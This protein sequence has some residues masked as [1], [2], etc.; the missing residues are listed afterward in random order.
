[1]KRIP[2]HLFSVLLLIAGIFPVH[3]QQAVGP[4]E[5]RTLNVTYNL[6]S[7]RGV[8]ISN[9]KG[10][11][12]G[13][14]GRAPAQGAQLSPLPTT[15][16]TARQFQSVVTFGGGVR[17]KA[18]GVNIN[19]GG[20]VANAVGLDLPRLGNT[21]PLYVLLRSQVGAPVVSRNLSVLFGG[22]ISVPSTDEFGKLL[23]P[24]VAK[25]S[26]WT[27]EP[28]STDGHL[29]DQ[30]Y[31]SPNAR[32]VFAT[33]PGAI[34]ITWRRRIGQTSA[35]VTQ[36]N[37]VSLLQEGGLWYSLY[38][39][40]LVVSGTL[41]KP[42]KP[43][44]W[45]ARDFA[46][47]GKPVQ[48][49]AGRVSD[50]K[51]V[52]NSQ[53]PARVDQ[54]YSSGS[55]I[56][57]NQLPETR[58]VWF[59]KQ[60]SQ[61]QAYNREGRVFIELLGDLKADGSRQ[62]LGFELVDV[63]QQANPQDIGVELG[64]KLR[65]FSDATRDDSELF[66]QSVLTVGV[67]YFDTLTRGSSKPPILYATRETQN[68]NDVLVYWM[69]TG[70][71]GLLW[72]RVL[73]RYSMKWPSDSARYSHYLRP[74]VSS[75]VEAQ[76]TAVALPRQNIPALVYQDPLDQERAKVTADADFYSYLTP[77]YPAH[78]TLLRYT[79]SDDYVYERVLSWL[80]V[81][82]KSNLWTG[83]VVTN[84]TAYNPTNLSIVFSEATLGPRIVNSTAFVGSRVMAPQGELGS[85]PGGLYVAGHIRKSVGTSYNPAAY[86]DPLVD[87]FDAAAKGS[88][89]PV[90]AIPGSNQLEVWWFR[91]SSAIVARGLSPIA[92]P[93][94]IGR[95][96]LQYPAAAAELVLASN[97]GTKALDSLQ[98][99][100][101]IYF[102]NDRNAPGYNP[103]E[104]HA[105]MV[106]GQGWALRDDLNITNGANF[107]S[108]P[109]VLIA[110]DDADGRPSMAAFKVLREKP[111]DGYLFDYVVDAGTVVQ[112]PMP[113]PLLPLPLEGTTNYNNEV[114]VLNGNLPVNWN[115]SRDANG[116][117]SHYAQFTIRDRKNAFWVYRGL[118]Q[119][120]A[121]QSGSYNPTTRA[122]TVL[123]KAVAVVGQD[124][125]YYIHASRR[126]A[127]LVLKSS[128]ATPL[129]NWLR[130]D[131]DFE[132]VFLAGSP[133]QTNGSTTYSLI[134]TDVGAAQTNNLDFSL[135]VRSSGVVGVQGPL[136]LSMTTTDGSNVEFRGRPPYLAQRASDTNSFR[137]RYY[138]KTLD[139]FAWPS[140]STPVPVG[141]IVPYLR[142]V[143]GA[144]TYVGTGADKASTALDIVYRPAWPSL[145]PVLQ[146]GQT[147]T[148]ATRGL[149][150]IRGQ[151]SLKVLYQQSIATNI[152]TASPSVVLHDP[153]RAKYASLSDF[154]LDT[155]PSS[156]VATG[157][158]GKFYF[159]MLPPH[160]VGR[161]YF[162]PALGTKGS[163][164]LKG[165]FKDEQV[166][167]KY[168]RL[169]VLRG[170]GSKDDFASVLGLCSSS[171]ADDFPKWTNLV[172]GLS[173]SVETFKESSIKPGT[174]IVDPN[175]T[176]QVGVGGLAEIVN[177][178]T[179]V[180]SYAL[181]TPGPGYGY[182]TLIAGNGA[183]FTS[184][185]DP[186]SMYILRV[187]GGLWPGELKVV[188]SPNP[189]NEQLTL[190]HTADVGGRY[191]QFEY[192]WRISA[193]VDG[194]A[195][196]TKDM[197]QWQD[198][199]SGTGLPR[200]TLGGSG[201]QVLSDNY[202]IMRYRSV[203]TNDPVVG[204]WSAWTEPQL[205]EGW[206]KRVLAGIN[207]FAQRVTD[208]YNNEVNTDV[209]VI[210]QAGTRW[211]GAVP[212]NLNSAN[213]SGLISIYETVARRA[214]DLSIN[215]GI[216]YGPGNDALLL[217][218]G[219]LNDLYDIVGNEANADASNPTIATTAVNGQQDA[220]STARFSFSGQVSSLLEEELALLRGR[221][222]FAAP[223]VQSA[224]VYNRLYWNYTRGIDS[225]EVVYAL[226]YNMK[227]LNNDGAVN[228]SDA[229][230]A[231]PQGHGDAYGH[232][233]TA[234]KGYYGLLMNQSF[235]WVPRT[236]AVTIL[237]K[238]VAVDYQDER[239]FAATAS[240]LAQ[241]GLDV[242]KLVF[243]QG[244]KS[245][246]GLGWSNL[247][248]T[249]VNTNR[250]LPSTRYWGLDHWASRVGQGAYLH[251]LVSNSLLPDVD[252]DPSHEGIQKIDRTTVAELALLPSA[253]DEA[254]ALVDSAE[255]GLTPLGLSR[256]SVAF[257]L[258]P[259]A[260]VG[261]QSKTH[262]EQV[263]DRAVGA[264]KNAAAAYG[265]ASTISLN[266]QTESNSLETDKSKIV[267]TERSMTEK[268]I[269]LYG[270][271]YPDDIGVGKTYPQD[272]NGPDLMHYLYV[273]MP[274]YTFPMSDVS[275]SGT[276]SYTF[277]VYDIPADMNFGSYQTV[278]TGFNSEMSSSDLNG[279]YVDGLLNGFSTVTNL[280]I[281]IT[282]E[283]YT[284]R[285]PDWSTERA[286][287]GKIQQAVS[288]M[289]DSQ[290]ML[291]K[292]WDSFA[293]SI[294]VWQQS[295]AVFRAN[296]ETE[297]EIRNSQIAMEAVKSALAS[298]HLA[299]DIFNAFSTAQEKITE[300][301]AKAVKE[302]LPQSFIAGVAAG[303]DLTSPA[304]AAVEAGANAASSA[305]ELAKAAKESIL[306]ALDFSGDQSQAWTQTFYIDPRERLIEL[307][308]SIFDLNKQLIDLQG[309]F[310]DI[311]Q[312]VR[313]YCDARDRL[314]ALVAEGNRLQSE[315][316]VFRRSAA[317]LIQ[318]Y[319]TRDVAFRLFRNEKLERYRTLMD[320]ASQY[321]LLAAN[322]YDYET[323]LLGTSAGR[324]FIDRVIQARALGVVKDGIPQFTGSSSTD[325]GLSGALAE[326]YG[327]WSVLKARL[328][329]N[330]PDGY[331]TT[332]SLRTEKFR[333]LPTSEGDS[334]W[335]DVLQGSR[336]ANIRDDMDVR[337]MCMQ[338]NQPNGTPI[339]GLIVDF[340]T[341]V[342]DGANFFG[343][344]LAAKDHTYSSTA[345]ATKIFAVGVALEG[346]KGMD[347]PSPASGSGGISPT[348]PDLSFMDPD[349]LAATP[350]IFL[351]PVGVD[352]MRSPPLGDQSAVRSWSVEDVT[353]PVPFNVGGSDF[354][355]KKLW[356]GSDSLTEP[357]FGIRKHQAFR[358]VPSATSFS[359]SIY[360]TG[361]LLRS[362]FTNSR[363]VAR[364][365]WNSHWK[366][367]IPGNTLLNNPD[368][369]LD[370]FIRTV[371]DIK[372]YVISYSYAGN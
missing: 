237:G 208:L 48:V 281:S 158:Q 350:Y 77:Q 190:E 359:S 272:Y 239:K 326:L 238:T 290:R 297:Q 76:L 116:S 143:A 277:N 141:S 180:D 182:V 51:V 248:Q 21:S 92:W 129:P 348:D 79:V 58:T 289:I 319:R 257:D 169:N 38:T 307:R 62:H 42:A 301:V 200:F 139:G 97:Q 294:N 140:L 204:N 163:L 2:C 45:T 247:D 136:R 273:T 94:V 198:L 223:G 134:L 164:V 314:R 149:P 109:Y 117:F 167:E 260:I 166:G 255:A 214:K 364:S 162:D 98:A 244:Y 52:F 344:P 261:G 183:A 312:E 120:P 213:S 115:S 339:P 203:N 328:G 27:E 240:A 329:F 61:I 22:V 186:V 155:L 1:M 168:L 311:N 119:E 63:L 321:A 146:P 333:I 323:G 264:I 89:I 130:I 177:D 44:Y 280:T 65:A 145:P 74:L 57:T 353:I 72:P 267:D 299:F 313:R 291:V 365:V 283:G 179:A 210:T 137:M 86:V 304:R 69:E 320:L 334:S 28:Y 106:G 233:L 368:D 345:F 342:S 55:V 246:V 351:I 133:N 5:L 309:G 64:D 236:E 104:E 6:S 37:G 67:S 46:T 111:T 286:S 150:S 95:Y 66:P 202:V 17:P 157:N 292:S 338:M 335:R 88:I 285:P 99:K 126:S 318:G 19:P 205:A 191:S 35:M 41:V 225:G 310:W 211:E 349:A 258:D 124:F 367:V 151:S 201:I 173:A 154:G 371:S 185:A 14:D 229:A 196:S 369:G 295:E 218:T 215:A 332:F 71:Q 40:K 235:D 336:V 100:G 279:R 284:P 228:A 68:L 172:S 278:S 30:F 187:G 209:S 125:K 343:R 270:T 24:S 305:I 341:I 358:P 230:I 161:V 132:G 194:S 156:I 298:T 43:I 331:G 269:E 288:D 60:L 224:P 274:E 287:P 308:N 7:V 243:R 84:L 110:Y 251:W 75:D 265:E 85:V 207:P 32:M 252:P 90:N 23:D 302:M 189:M 87:G 199:Q 147:L 36:P 175:A 174:F 222:D 322:A 357:L 49:P 153:T 226:N 317:A 306:L 83:G 217:V 325:P 263:Y 53:V 78:R 138:Y 82:V 227:D 3:G 54:E 231:Y 184:S 303:G 337:R 81:A 253:F 324:S 56:S 370:R 178:N 363:L 121:L 293:S 16:G 103:N 34:T 39:Q 127:G 249:R 8:P 12:A 118:H 96:T 170:T 355:S 245:G 10:I 216:N 232:Y 128:T 282:A 105:L 241:T 193:P 206:V 148:V 102:Q 315:R 366:L 195:P 20:L 220:M 192:Q 93:A 372:L 197:S 135:E 131:S 212:L 114:P 362:Q 316:L 70:S 352:S 13:S 152:N 330:N 47:I 346:Y 50:V 29:S 259:N 296:W 107:S 340:S 176:Q 112:A 15:P 347:A 171:A 11:P 73:A 108:L 256:G 219:Y 360:N 31:W 122:F 144:G 271:P 234:L 165:E 276:S 18:A 4:A 101:S 300:D 242:M 113:L 275:P 26:Y 80:D 160:L 181:S 123:A 327:D 354:S 221:D 33:Q 250:A 9:T 356:Q 268:L 188:P 59:D 91:Q 361:V 142:P 266:L 254:Q 25:E 159:P 262:F